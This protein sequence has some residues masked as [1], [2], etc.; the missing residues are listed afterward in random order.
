[1]SLLKPIIGELGI[2]KAGKIA[3]LNKVEALMDR[4]KIC[5]HYL[6][7]EA[8]ELAEDIG[9]LDERIKQMQ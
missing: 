7:Y 6:L 9:R 4:L 2:K 1:M 5:P 3:R 8:I